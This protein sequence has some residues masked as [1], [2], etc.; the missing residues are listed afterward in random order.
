MLSFGNHYDTTYPVCTRNLWRER[1]SVILVHAPKITLVKH[2]SGMDSIKVCV[3]CGMQYALCSDVA[4]AP[5]QPPIMAR[6][7][8]RHS[9]TAHFRK[10]VRDGIGDENTRPHECEYSRH[11][12]FVLFSFIGREIAAACSDCPTLFPF[13]AAFTYISQVHFSFVC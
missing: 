12:F 1:S 2:R 5:G 9:F 3:D 10:R 8:C 7:S 6:G 4:P 11:V 13:P